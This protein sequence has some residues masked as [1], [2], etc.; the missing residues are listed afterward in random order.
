MMYIILIHG[1]DKMKG[2]SGIV[3]IISTYYG[4]TGNGG[5]TPTQIQSAYT[6]QGT[7]FRPEW[8]DECILIQRPSKEFSQ[9]G[10]EQYFEK[11]T[12]IFEVIVSTLTSQTRLNEIILEL[13][14]ICLGFAGNTDYTRVHL[15]S[16]DELEH[17]FYFMIKGTII[18]YMNLSHARE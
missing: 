3:S 17:S 1:E 13:R 16:I 10:I 8:T 5:S 15:D 6:G 7:Y 12:E 9:Q 14:R 4:A 18:G 2:A 11:D